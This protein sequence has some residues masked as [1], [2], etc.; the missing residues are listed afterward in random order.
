M[1][2]THG[3]Q[4]RL[5]NRDREPRNVAF[6]VVVPTASVHCQRSNSMHGRVNGEGEIAPELHR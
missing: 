6:L 1:L 5:H 2:Q 3:E 4:I